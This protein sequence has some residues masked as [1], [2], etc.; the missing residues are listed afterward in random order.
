MDYLVHTCGT[1]GKPT[2]FDLY[3]YI[4]L[5][6][7]MGSLH[8]SIKLR[9]SKVLKLSFC[10]EWVSLHLEKIWK[11]V[12]ILNTP[13]FSCSW[14]K[15]NASTGKELA[16]SLFANLGWP[17]PLWMDENIVSRRQLTSHLSKEDFL[18]N[19]LS[20]IICFFC[21]IFK[22]IMLLERFSL[23][24]IILIGFEA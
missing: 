18:S 6:G 13:D 20:H 24:F 19:F 23:R 10:N 11:E 9:K 12:Q 14:T 16:S 3:T 21:V 4:T 1:N 15:G 2:S 5:V 22:P 7:Q 8:H 17:N